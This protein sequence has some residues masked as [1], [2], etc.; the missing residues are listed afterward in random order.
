MKQLSLIGAVAALALSSAT[1]MAA[2]LYEY[3]INNPAGSD[4]A[5][6]ITN[7]TTSYDAGT[8]NFS[9]SYTIDDVA[10]NYSDAFWLVVSDGPNPKGIAGQLAILYGD[11]ATNTL[12]AYEYNGVNGNNSYANPANLLASWS[13]ALDVSLSG[14]LQTVSFDIDVAGVNSAPLGA[15]WEGIQFGEKVGIWFHPSLNSSIQYGQNG[16]ITSY[17]FGGQGWY[18]TK[19]RI[20]TVSVPEPATLSLL[21]LG[22]AGLML[23]RRRA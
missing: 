23:S 18:D 7:V 5:G 2:P 21:G 12:T 19:D 16:E 13:G 1:A 8:S 11:V 10:G 15:D 22:V 17:R 14:G 4:G 9:W 6:D 3:S 20:T